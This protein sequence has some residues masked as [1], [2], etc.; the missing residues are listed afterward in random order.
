MDAVRPTLDRRVLA[1]VVLLAIVVAAPSLANGF[2]YDD[3]WVIVRDQ[4]KHDLARWREWLTEAYWILG[5]PAMYRPLTTTLFALEWAAADGNPWVFPAVNI[6]FACRVYG[7]RAL[8]GEPIARSD[9]GGGR[10]RDVRGP[11][12]PDRLG[13]VGYGL[14]AL[15]TMGGVANCRT[16][17]GFCPTSRG[18]E[19]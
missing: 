16:N 13:A 8:A 11:S 7:S 17:A 19:M 9:H 14:P 3:I 12:G 10:R 15:A 6:G 4:R 5:S 2:A 18:S 1:L